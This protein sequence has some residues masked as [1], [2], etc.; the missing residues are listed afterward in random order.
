MQRHNYV[1][2]PKESTKA[3]PEYIK[4]VNSQD[5]NTQ[6]L[7]VYVYIHNEHMKAK[8]KDTIPPTISIKMK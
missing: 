4:S 6:K 7:I 8:I 5:T 2:N 3:F 1:E